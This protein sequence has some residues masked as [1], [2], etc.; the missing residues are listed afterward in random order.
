[1][2]GTEPNRW[3]R[4]GLVL[5]LPVSRALV[6]VRSEG[7]ERI[8][9]RGAA[10][11]AFD[12]VSLLDGPLLAIEVM[13]RARRKTRFLVA[14][15]I[16]RAPIVGSIL[17]R[18][19]QIPIQRGKGDEGALDLA[20]SAVRDGALAAIAPEGQ[21]NPH[22]DDGLQRI[23][24][25][26]ARITLASGAPLLPVGIW[27][28]QRRW[29]HQ[30]PRLGRPLRPNVGISVGAPIL[31]VGDVEDPEV[32]GAFTVRIAEGLRRQVAIAKTLARLSAS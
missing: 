15:E 4:V 30:G 18:Y 32:V 7:L 11:L 17:R 28:T 3:W 14:A 5:V 13:R 1:M 31:P 24:A 16:F 21:V 8:P 20:V 6:R 25:G 29:P 22:A 27:G 19:E 10:V 23:R 9:S 2:S 12:H 26:A